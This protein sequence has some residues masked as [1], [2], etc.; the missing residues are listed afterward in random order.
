MPGDGMLRRRV[1]GLSQFVTVRGGAYVF[2]PS[3]RAS[4]ELTRL[5]SSGSSH[6][7]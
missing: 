2:L 3:L 4:R 7:A 5:G 6:E 1:S